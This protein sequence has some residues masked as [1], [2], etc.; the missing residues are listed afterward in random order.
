MIVE[1]QLG[2]LQEEVLVVVVEEGILVQCTTSE[3]FDDE[4]RGAR[5]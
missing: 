2:W 5:L 3:R 1:I 4:E